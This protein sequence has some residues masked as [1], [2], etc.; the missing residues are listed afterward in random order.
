MKTIQGVYANEHTYSLIPT[1]KLWVNKFE[2][3][4]LSQM[5]IGGRHLGIGLK[6]FNQFVGINIHYKK[7]KR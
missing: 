4:E 1:I 2:T 7:T 3:P 5:G 6:W